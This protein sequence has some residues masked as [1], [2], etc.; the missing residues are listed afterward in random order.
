MKTLLRRHARTLL[1]LSLGLV[2]AA[3]ML[4]NADAFELARPAF[5]NVD[6]TCQPPAECPNAYRCC[7]GTAYCP[8]GGGGPPGPN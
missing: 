4:W 3:G 7:N 5:A 8:N 2:I 1:D 6:P